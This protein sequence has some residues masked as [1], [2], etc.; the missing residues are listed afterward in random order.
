MVPLTYIDNQSI[1]VGTAD[2]ECTKRTYSCVRCNS[3]STSFVTTSPLKALIGYDRVEIT[4]TD[5]NNNAGIG[6]TIKRF[7]NQNV[8]GVFYQDVILN[9]A[10]SIGDLLSVSHL[11]DQGTLVSKDSMEYSMKDIQKDWVNVKV[12]DHYIGPEGVCNPQSG[13]NYCLYHGRF[14]I[15]VYPYVNFKNLMTRKTE[16][17]YEADKNIQTVSEYSYNMDNYC[18]SEV[19]TESSKK[20][21]L[22]IAYKYPGDVIADG[23]VYMQMVYH[24]IITPVIEETQYKGKT[25]LVKRVKTNYTIF[26][27][28]YLKPSLVEQQLGNYPTESYLSYTKYVNGNVAEYKSSDGISK[29]ILWGYNGTRPIAE[30]TNAEYKNIFYTGFEDGDGNSVLNDCRTGFN[31]KIGGYSKTLSNLENGNYKLSYWNKISGN[32][33]LKEQTV[34]I[35]SNAYTISLSGQVDDVRFYPAGAQM[36]TFTYDSLVGMTS[37]ADVN[38]Q[39]NYF[40]YDEF[41]RLTCIKDHDRNIIKQV[42]YHYQP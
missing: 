41:Q 9:D 39:A 42:S 28:F 14:T 1:T 26:D 36:E 3:S 22:L 23:L 2:A 29:A 7:S 13:T 40:E 27:N 32:W 20:D 35:S 5:K 31:S 4:Q 10:I 25:A 19:K 33:T 34:N 6:K 38:D 21:T 11:N 16:T 18:V 37:R 12:K 24:N 17:K 15:G 8:L 30:V